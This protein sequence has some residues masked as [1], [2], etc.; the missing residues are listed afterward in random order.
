MVHVT[1]RG[2]SVQV[3]LQPHPDSGSEHLLWY[4]HI[5]STPPLQRRCRRVWTLLS[6]SAGL[7][8]AKPLPLSRT[9]RHTASGQIGSH[10]THNTL[11]THHRWTFTLNRKIR[12][13]FRAALAGSHHAQSGSSRGRRHTQTTSIHAGNQ[14]AQRADTNASGAERARHG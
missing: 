6:V 11:H 9:E 8:T 3:D 4:F 7:L 1:F 12:A 13:A 14:A 5:I 10:H 2:S